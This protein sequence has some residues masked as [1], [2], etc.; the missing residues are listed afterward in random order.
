MV[1][2][3]PMY[4]SQILPRRGQNTPIWPFNS[5]KGQINRNPTSLPIKPPTSFQ[6]K[7]NII[8]NR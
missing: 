4:T 3:K 7:S 8:T 5:G 2:H 1:H 6:E